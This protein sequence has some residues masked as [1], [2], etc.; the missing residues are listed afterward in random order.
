LTSPSIQDA[1]RTFDAVHAP[2]GEREP[3]TK[4]EGF[5]TELLSA[6]G[7]IKCYATNAT[8]PSQ[9]LKNKLGQATTI[10]DGFLTI[11]FENRE[12]HDRAVAALVDQWAGNAGWQ[13]VVACVGVVYREANGWTIGTIV[14]W[15]PSRFPRLV[16]ERLFP[17]VV[18][19][20]AKNSEASR[21]IVD[22]LPELPADSTA[23]A[24]VTSEPHGGP[25]W[26]L[27]TCL[28]SPTQDVDGNDA[29]AIM[30]EPQD[31]DLVVHMVKEPAGRTIVGWSR[32]AGSAAERED[33]PKVDG[34]WTSQGPY[35]RIPLKDFHRLASPP[36]VQA[37]QDASFPLIRAEAETATGEHYPFQKYRDTVR[38]RSGGYLSRCT[39]TL[40][41]AIRDFLGGGQAVT[42]PAAIHG[43]CAAFAAAL[44]DAN[45]V[46][47]TDHDA[48]VRTFVCS[49]AA[50]RFVILTG[51]SGSG[52]TQI[53]L[54]FGEWLGPDRFLVVPVRPD[55]TGPD[56]LLGYEDALVPPSEGRRAWSTPRTLEFLLRAL[57]DPGSPYVLVLDEMNLAHVERYFAD[58]LSAL[59]SRQPILP[60]LQKDGGLWRVAAD[61]LRPLPDNLIILGTVNVDETT[62]MFSPKVLDRANTLEFR[63]H[64]S[65][66][67]SDATTLRRPGACTAGAA[68]LVS[69]F[70]AIARDD[71]WQLTNPAT[72]AP[73]FV[74]LVRLIHEILSESGDEFGHRTFYEGARLAAVLAAAG[75]ESVEA[76]ADVFALQ[77]V[78]P[79]LH[80]AR[81]RLQPV[82]QR[83]GAFFLSLERDQERADA[84]DL[85]SSKLQPAMPRSFAKTLRMLRALRANQFASFSD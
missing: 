35:Y 39:R 17:D 68:S 71:E 59:E 48:W 63:V 15:R 52:K 12:V 38:L 78:L 85:A 10:K 62:Y 72:Y 69:T 21:V 25:G 13:K 32:V 8:N 23:W 18:V 46:Y 77:K 64:T 22:A 5:L 61:G 81:R 24:E 51:L 75:E 49:A 30:R 80:G 70:L 53:A 28:W 1:Q 11:S 50:K 66:L 16:I 82:L 44:R 27:G 42:T 33:E 37:F 60:S 45:V 57:D 84:L 26:E 56:A 2:I 29:Y 65:A 34:E 14:E 4:L 40:Y 36:T 79:R 58:V 54:K 19:V 76:A 67:P 3:Q 83:L 31:G 7:S 43:V 20:P 6:P 55:W 74:E 73:R 47:G 41:D 9:Q